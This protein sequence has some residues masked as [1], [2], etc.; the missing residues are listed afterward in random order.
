M[1]Y[2]VQH[3]LCDLQH[4]MGEMARLEFI[5]RSRVEAK[6]TQNSNTSLIEN[7]SGMCLFI[8]S[9]NAEQ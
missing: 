4:S 3:T 6:R 1:H 9:F 2:A 5:F 8:V 7:L